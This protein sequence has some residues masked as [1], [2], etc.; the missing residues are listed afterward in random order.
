MAQVVI[1]HGIGHQYGGAATL[2]NVCLPALR[3]GLQRAG[4][5]AAADVSCAFYGDFFRAPERVLGSDPP[6]D[7]S[8]VEPGFE[9][10]L[11]LAWWDEAA[12]LDPRVPPPDA[13]TLARTP[14]SAQAAL[15]ALSGSVFFTGLA[16]RLM[17]SNLRQ[18]RRYLTEPEL[19]K[20]ITAR[21]ADQ[22]SPD[23]AVVVGHSLGSVV[24]YEVL[25]ANA[26][27]QVR[28][29]ITLGSPLG[30]RNLCFDRLLPVPG[31]WPGRVRSWTNIADA[32]DVV[33]LVKDLRPLFG[34]RVRN[35]LVNNGSHAHDMARYLTTEAVGRAVADGLAMVAEA[36]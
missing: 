26:A 25:C 21:V 5:T 35:V 29:L 13:R 7:A 32:G 17:V 4:V 34:E 6:Y 27:P 10:E 22:L 15:N 8:D 12:R 31:A 24:A 28:A 3:D 33:A 19:R 18:V 30:I 11:L 2:A 36:G 14:R 16:E 9:Q 1:V 23:T 20:K